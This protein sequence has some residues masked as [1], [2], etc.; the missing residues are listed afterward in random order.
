MLQKTDFFKI[1]CGRM[2]RREPI[3]GAKEA[4]GAG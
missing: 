4:G 2:N 3:A 1:F